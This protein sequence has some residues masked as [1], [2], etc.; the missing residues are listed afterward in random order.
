MYP[1]Y[2]GTDIGCFLKF[3]Y[4]NN[5]KIILTI[6]SSIKNL[7]SKYNEI[8]D[9]DYMFSKGFSDLYTHSN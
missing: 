8:N 3:K 4:T 1:I 7:K 9:L 2:Q 6:Y 5:S